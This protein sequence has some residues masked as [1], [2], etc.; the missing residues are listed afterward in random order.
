MLDITNECH[1]NLMARY[2]D[3]WFDLAIVDPPYKKDTSG[4]NV[5]INRNFNYDYFQPPDERYIKELF[6]VSKHQIIW[7]FNYFLEILP[8]TDAIIIWNKHQNGH[9]SECELAWSS[10]GKTRICDRPYQKD[11]G[12]KIHPTQKPVYLYKFILE[13]YAKPGFKILDT[14]GGSLSLAIACHDYG[15]DLTV[16]EIDPDIYIKAMDRVNLHLSQGNLFL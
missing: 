13:N 4:L 6:R 11:I 14:H 15:F 2:P 1:Y 8:S 16:C 7:G 3:K 10:I 12:N 5:G 9:F